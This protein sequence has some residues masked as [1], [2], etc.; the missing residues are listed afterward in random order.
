VKFMTRL[1]TY[2]YKTKDALLK[3][4]AKVLYADLKEMKLERVEFKS[5]IKLE[6]ARIINNLR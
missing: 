5:K 3:E 6:V 2:A 4:H 1:F